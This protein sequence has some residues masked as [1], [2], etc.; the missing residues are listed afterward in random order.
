[1]ILNEQS[2]AEIKKR[3]VRYPRRKS[4]ILPAL[5]LAYRQVGH[6][7]KEV[8]KEISDIIEIPYI[9]IAEAATFYTMFPK[10]EVGK[11]LIQVC[12][13]ISCALL[14]ADGLIDYLEQ[15]LDIKKGETS[16]VFK[17]LGEGTEGVQQIVKSCGLDDCLD[18]GAE[19]INWKGLRGRKQEVAPGIFR[20][21][22]LSVSMQGSGIPRIDMGAANMKMNEDG[23]FNLYI[24]ATDIGTGSDTVLAQIAAET[25]G[26]PVDDIIVLSSDT[27]LTPFDVG[28]YASSTTYISGGAVRNCAE[29]IRDQIFTVAHDMKG[30]DPSDLTLKDRA[31]INGNGEKISLAE[32]CT[33]AMYTHNQ[34][35]IQASGSHISNESPP[36][37]IAQFADITVDTKTG[38]IQVLK[39]VSAVDCGQPLNP[40]L[41]EGQVEGAVVN[42]LSYALTEEY[43]FDSS[44]RTTNPRFWDYKIYTTM[45]MPELI[46]ILA[47]SYEETGPYGA[48]SVGEIAING[49][50]PAIANA[51]FDAVGVRLFDTPFTPEKVLAR[52]RE[53]RS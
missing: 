31:V 2:V 36:P 42:G 9:E 1:M 25:L 49:P 10:H 22:G 23:S 40:A 51:V 16:P 29:K 38:R 45:D 33:W 27:D 46:T 53:S 41:A 43:K 24:G 5:T 12:H 18:K 7:N 32:I 15:K 4:A 11:Y 47:E 28:A 39:F 50:I 26:I 34:F 52:I 3:M 14:G 21:I 44:G 30:W 20:G 35:Q 48:K 13:N 37:F 17:A 19:A 6:L 8:Y